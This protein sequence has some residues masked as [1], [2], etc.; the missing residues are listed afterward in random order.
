MAEDLHIQQSRS[1]R[2][3]MRA[4]STWQW[5]RAGWDSLQYCNLASYQA[6]AN[7]ETHAIQLAHATHDM[8]C[9]QP[10]RLQCS[11]DTH[12]AEVGNVGDGVPAASWP[13]EVLAALQRRV[14]DLRRV[15]GTRVLKNPNP[16]K[17]TARMTR[18]SLS[19]LLGILAC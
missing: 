10:I 12:P 7:A 16:E 15:P 8:Q 1:Q 9:H 13:C 17:I 19:N 14:Q 6:E 4:H 2:W 5:L 18:R 11:W 3:Q